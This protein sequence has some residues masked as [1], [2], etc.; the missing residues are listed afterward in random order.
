ML[1]NKKRWTQS[2]LRIVLKNKINKQDES[3]LKIVK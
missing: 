1:R 3:H 2:K